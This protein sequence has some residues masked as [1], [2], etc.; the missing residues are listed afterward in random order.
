MNRWYAVYTRSNYEKL[1]AEQL[2]AK[3]V[4][5]FLPVSRESHR[6]KDRKKV[7]EVPVFRSYVFARFSDDHDSRLRVFQTVGSVRILGLGDR[8]EPIPDAEIDGVRRLL[9][10]GKHGR[11]HPFLKEGSLVRVK[12][13][14]LVGLEGLFV[15][16]KNGSDRLVVSVNLLRKSVSAEIGLADI[17]VLP[18]PRP[19]R[20][21]TR[22]LTSLREI[23]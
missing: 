15:R 6:W 13:G 11:P 18:A 9:T 12:S 17:E 19:D 16:Q 7:V 21:D 10:A 2:S 23:A 3:R 14:P 20:L 8:I 1:V 5:N 4:E 22:T